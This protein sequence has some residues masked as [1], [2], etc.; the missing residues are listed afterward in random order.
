[1][2][3]QI[4]GAKSASR[5]A[6]TFRVIRRVL[7]FISLAIFLGGAA[8]ALFFVIRQPKNDALGEE[9]GKMFARA[10]FGIVACWFAFGRN[11]KKPSAPN[12]TA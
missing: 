2:S 3:D 4:G 9:A 6:D 11:S 1:V 5:W 12:K 10:F 8:I 7:W